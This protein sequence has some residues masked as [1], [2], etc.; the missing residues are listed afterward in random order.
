MTRFV[1]ID[2][3]TTT[4]FVALDEEGNVLVATDVRGEGKRIPGGISTGMLVSLENKVYSLLRPGDIIAIEEPAV[5]TQ[6]AVTAGMIHGG[7]RSMIYRKEL[8]F[9][10]VNPQRTK[11]FVNRNQRVEYSEKKEHVAA[12]VLEHYGFEH[13]SDNVADAY[14]IARIAEAVYRVKNGGSLDLYTSYQQRIIQA[15][16]NP[17]A[18]TPKTKKGKSQTIKRRGKPATA[19]S[20]IQNA[21]QTL[22]F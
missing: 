16:L 12:G 1:G 4:G 17:E 6:M 7:L 15:I 2:P 14:I 11:G 8:E 5:H 10:D 13:S 9:I 3:A 22:L 20:H 18:K 21:E 19:D